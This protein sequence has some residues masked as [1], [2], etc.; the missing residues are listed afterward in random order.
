MTHY[1]LCKSEN[2]YTIRRESF[3]KNFGYSEN[4]EHCKPTVSISNTVLTTGLTGSPREQIVLRSTLSQIIW[5]ITT[6]IFKS[7]YQTIGGDT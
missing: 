5:K 3:S 6:T 2:K 4:N 1:A 7:K